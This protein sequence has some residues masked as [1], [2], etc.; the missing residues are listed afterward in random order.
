MKR[1]VRASLTI[2]LLTVPPSTAA[3][4]WDGWQAGPGATHGRRQHVAVPLATK[5]VLMV[6][7]ANP[8]EAPT[9]EIYDPY[10]NEVTQTANPPPARLH[11]VQLQSGDVMFVG[12][13]DPDTVQER[14]RP[15]A[16]LYDEA[17]EQFV[18][19]AHGPAVNRFNAMLV[20]LPTGKVLYVG[21]Q[22][23][24]GEGL[25]SA[26]LYDPFSDEW[27]TVDSMSAPR[28]LP[29]ATVLQNGMVLV[30]GGATVDLAEAE[31]HQALEVFDPDGQIWFGAGN[32]VLPR[33]G[34][35]ATLLPSGQVLIAG[36]F[37]AG[38]TATA[39]TEL[40]EPLDAISA[41]TVPL[42]APRAFHQAAPLGS[43]QILVAG[44]RGTC[45]NS[46]PTLATSERYDAQGGDGWLAPQAMVAPRSEHALTILEDGKVVASGGTDGQD[47]LG[48]TEVL[49]P[50]ARAAA[51]C[52]PCVQDHDCPSN[53]CDQVTRYCVAV[54]PPQTP[55]AYCCTNDDC[56]SGRCGLYNHCE[57][58]F[59]QDCPPEQYCA[60]KADPVCEARE[61]Q[62][63]PKLNE[64][65]GC[66]SNAATQCQ[67]PGSVCSADRQ[68]VV[69][70]TRA[71][72][73]ACCATEQCTSGICCGTCAQP[74]TRTLGQ[75]CCNNHS[76]CISNYCGNNNTCQ[77]NDDNDCGPGNFC[78]KGLTQNSCQ[79]KR[80]TCGSCSAD[81]QCISG[82]C[83]GKP[84][85]RCITPNSNFPIGANCCKDDECATGSCNS[86]GHCQCKTDGHCPN[87]QFCDKGMLGIGPNTCRPLGGSCSSCSQDSHCASNFCKDKPVG[88]C[89]T[90]NSN[91]SVGQNCC[92]N[93]QCASGS[94]N[95]GGHC[96]CTADGHCPGGQFCDKG[97]F[98]FG[99]NT[100]RPLTGVCGGCSKD[101]QCASGFCQGKPFGQCIVPN[102]NFSV[103][104]N[105]CR[106]AQCQS[107]SCNS[108]GHCQCTSDW[109]CP[110]GHYCS[111]P[112]F[113]PNTCT[114]KKGC[115]SFC[116][117]DSQCAS[118][119]CKWGKCKC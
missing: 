49:D 81:H 3:A 37:V 54:G 38:C 69:P 21:G 95:S 23:D 89:I 75:A 119:N 58:V 66:C 34:H 101:S 118:N 5:R 80:A 29:A 83:K 59:D 39:S 82:F 32:L 53:R 78:H 4:Q 50:E 85:G 18:E 20:L 10:L 103:G 16:W 42:S 47:T 31:L 98:G 84:L 68:C 52:Q 27:T 87:G 110:G 26:E 73:Q 9:A 106:D 51:A 12:G 11:G 60:G 91:F 88:R 100:C 15:A 2:L 46:G 24:T 92:K 1:L 116:L 77:C 30:S 48:S 79:P 114:S 97:L 19:M 115:G 67:T 63:K 57:C 44:G 117:F 111:K 33:F 40:Y 8:T 25:A 112:L 43:A 6:G 41:E 72:G 96:Q 86:G 61:A 71:I 107:G 108:G 22:D 65:A 35:T 45:D 104:A 102:S 99:P 113:G 7:S 90:P 17:Q 14:G 13:E 74:G 36:G 76:L 105:C 93:D 55:N 62:C 94:C 28:I 56:Q 70:S 109:Q 64:C